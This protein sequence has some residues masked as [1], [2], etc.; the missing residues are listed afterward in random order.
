METTY[1]EPAAAS[2]ELKNLI[3]DVED[4]VAS[5]THLQGKDIGAVRG[6]V[7]RALGAA[8]QALAVG[9]TSV[10]EGSRE[11]RRRAGRLAA[12]ADSYVRESPWQAVGIA[13]VLALAV[14][15]IATRRD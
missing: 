11:V 13:A 3:A 15:Y 4:L 9:G 14:G 10:L 1:R 12:G 5:I 2:G 6:R 8:K 7:E